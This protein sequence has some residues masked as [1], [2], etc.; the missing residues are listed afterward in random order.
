MKLAINNDKKPA[1]P[2]G[3][4]Y[5]V[6]PG[7]FLAG[8][9]PGAESKEN[10]HQKLK[11]LLEHGIRHVINL[12]EPHEI[13]WYG[14]L[15]VSYEE[16]MR[17]IAKS[18]GLTVGFEIMPIKDTRA[19]SQ[20]QMCHILDRIDYC[21]DHNKPVYV[22]CLGG[23]GRTGTVVGCFLVRHGFASGEKVLSLIQELR[24][25]TENFRYPSP[26]F[27]EQYDMVLSWVEGE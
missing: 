10:S 5:W 16:Q 7:K 4:A 8:F 2:F 21:I 22:H 27:P 23:R 19:P 3:H 18:M 24:K 6:I 12:M 1:V 25:D 14:D 13:D 9:Y 17:T 11:G 15:F 26:E 20:S